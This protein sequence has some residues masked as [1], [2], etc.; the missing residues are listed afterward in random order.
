M[1]VNKLSV[2]AYALVESFAAGLSTPAKEAQKNIDSM[3]GLPPIA[4]ASE[5]HLEAWNEVLQHA[6]DL[7]AVALFMEQHVSWAVDLMFSDMQ[8]MRE[9]RAY[10]IETKA[11]VQEKL[12]KLRKQAYSLN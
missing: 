2:G 1:S 6:L 4:Q 10:A 9:I 5:W 11:I 8:Q 12:A 7:T 3:R